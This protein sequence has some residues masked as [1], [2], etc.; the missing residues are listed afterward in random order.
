MEAANR[1]L[2]TLEE[3]DGNVTFILLTVNDRLLPLTVISRCQRLE[4]PPMSRR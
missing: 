1:L 4:L 3:P 2:K